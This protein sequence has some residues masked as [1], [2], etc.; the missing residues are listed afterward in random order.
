MRDL[1]EVYVDDIVVK[2]K[3]LAS[4]LDNLALVID[5]LP[6]MCM[7]L[8]LDKCVF[9]VT[10]GKLL[11]FLVSYQAIEANLEKIKTIKVMRPP[12][13]IKDVQKLTRSLAALSRFISRLAEW[14]LPFFM[15][16]QKSGHLIWTEEAEEVFQELRRYLTSPPIMVSPETGETLLLYIAV[17]I[18]TVSMV[19]VMERP[20]PCHHQEPT[21]E[22]AARS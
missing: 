9:G 12:A 13:R 18:D 6:S 16:L 1:V 19:L 7:K 22:E 11:G 20:E 2:I 3:S 15:L 17:T 21:V 14:A 5:R 8:N 10:S 4:L